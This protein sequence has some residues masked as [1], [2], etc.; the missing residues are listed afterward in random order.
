MFHVKTSLRPLGLPHVGCPCLVDG[1]RQALPAQLRH[2]LHDPF[3]PRFVH[4]GDGVIEQQQ[5]SDARRRTVHQDLSL[6]HDERIQDPFLFTPRGLADRAARDPDLEI[7]LLRPGLCE[8][9]FEITGA[10]AAEGPNR[11]SPSGHP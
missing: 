11:S 1:S 3:E 2:Y 7:G 8:A 9:P 5:W 10:T 6:G 4:L